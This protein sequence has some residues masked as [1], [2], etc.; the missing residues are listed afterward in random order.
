MLT[1]GTTGEPKRVALKR[2]SLESSFGEALAYESD[3]RADAAP[4]LRGATQI[5]T[6]PLA[7]IGGMWGALSAILAGRKICLLERF[8]VEAWRQAIVE[9]RP[10][11]SAVVPAGLRMVLDA[12]IP[13]K[14]LSSLV[15]LRTGT[16]PLD[17]AIVDEFLE[18]Y[19]IAVLQSYGATEFAGAVAGWTLKDFHAL[20]RTKVGSVGRLHSGVKA[21][22]LD[23]STLEVRASGEEGLLELNAPQLGLDGEWVRTTDLAVV[24]A[25][26]FLWIKGRVDNAIIRG[27]FKIHPADVIAALEQHP[28]VREAA[29]VGIDDHRLGQVPVAAIVPAAGGAPDPEELTAFLRE[30]LMPYQIPVAIRVVEDLPRTTSMKP[31]LPN[32]R[33]LFAS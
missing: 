29:V 11:I 20:Y 15:A 31:S 33:A 2:R 23:P 14:D 1:S 21:R 3:R 19:G 5:L 30:R 18:R 4:R 16:A 8:S 24:D 26:G 13:A 22:V 25:D 7:H 28:Q 12:N 9:H 6:N 10:K 27:G 32:V 17:A